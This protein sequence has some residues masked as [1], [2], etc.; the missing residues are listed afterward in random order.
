MAKTN[1]RDSSCSSFDYVIV[2]EAV[3]MC[4]HHLDEDLREKLLD[5]SIFDDNVQIPATILSILWSLSLEVV[6]GGWAIHSHDLR[7]HFSFSY[8]PPSPVTHAYPPSFIRLPL[9]ASLS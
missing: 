9:N 1:K 2:G 5:F 7:V 8:F 6:T 3:R 4:L